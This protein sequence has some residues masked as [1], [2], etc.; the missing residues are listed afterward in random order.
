MIDTTS[1]GGVDSSNID[2]VV[3]DDQLVLLTSKGIHTVKVVKGKFKEI[4]CVMASS[5]I[6]RVFSTEE[7]SGVVRALIK[8][9]AAT[10]SSGSG[11]LLVDVD[12]HKGQIKSSQLL[13]CSA[14]AIVPMRGQAD[15]GSITKSLT[16]IDADHSLVS[17]GAGVAGLKSAAESMQ[18]EENETDDA[19]MNEELGA[20]AVQGLGLLSQLYRM[21]PM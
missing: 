11:S 15:N 4:Q 8:I 10:S 12:L 3:Q 19:Q 9:A 14:L 16:L 7:G 13:R 18:I 21:R 17:L 5:R 20:G 2:C 6:S 1:L